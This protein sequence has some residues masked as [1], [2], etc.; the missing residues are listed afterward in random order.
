MHPRTIV[1]TKRL[2]ERRGEDKGCALI[3]GPITLS[4][5]FPPFHPP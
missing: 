3:A 2:K 5:L 1:N 4:H